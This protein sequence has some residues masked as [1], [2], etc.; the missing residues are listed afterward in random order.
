MIRGI[1]HAAIS[2]ADLDR[3]LDFYCGVIGFEVVSRSEW[4]DNAFIDELIGLKGSAA[5]Q[6]ML[7]AG[8]CH[9]EIFE[10]RAPQARSAGPLRPCDRGYTHIC[11][12]VVDIESEFDRL[13]RAGAVFQRRPGDFGGLKS[14]YGR[15]PDGNILEIQETIADHPQALERLG[16]LAHR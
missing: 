7:R 10:Y 2:T 13:T 3:L 15:D 4:A 16:P 6:A 1:H 5:R 14:V 8:N 12:D 11:L 9:L